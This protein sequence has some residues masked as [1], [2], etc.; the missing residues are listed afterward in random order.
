MA[1]PLARI[2]ILARRLRFSRALSPLSNDMS[3]PLPMTSDC[4]TPDVEIGRGGHHVFHHERTL[5]SRL[6]SSWYASAQV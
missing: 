3:S 6:T 2:L 4:L 5:I 1:C